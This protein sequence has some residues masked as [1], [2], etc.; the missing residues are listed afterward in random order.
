[1][2]KRKDILNLAAIIILCFLAGALGSIFTSRSVDT[3]YKQL[4]KPPFQPPNGIFGP[5]WT[6]LYLFMAVSFWLVWR[7]GK[8]NES[9][10]LSLLFFVQLLLNALWPFL[11]FGL[12]LMFPAFIE[13]LV[14]TILVG[15]YT[16]YSWKVSHASSL[17]FVPYWLWLC[18]ASY[19]NFMIWI[20]N[21]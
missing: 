11:F 13:I 17:L 7:K 21:S 8:R 19:L 4:L 3:W 5:V 1:M 10:T 6:I 16:L 15:S 20:I 14:L 12:R 2:S 18:F 9:R